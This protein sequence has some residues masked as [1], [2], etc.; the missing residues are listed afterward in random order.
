MN[1]RTSL[2]VQ[3][4]RVHPAMQGTQVGYLVSLRSHVPPGNLSKLLSLCPTTRELACC[5]HGEAIH[6]DSACRNKD[7]SETN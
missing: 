3:W 7:M 2:V 4:L 1:I 5:N 6:P